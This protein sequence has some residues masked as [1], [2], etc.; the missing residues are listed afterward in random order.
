MELDEV[1]R[2]IV[3]AL[4]VDGR[5]PA[6]RI[7]EVLGVSARTVVRRLARLEGAGVLRVVRVPEVSAYPDGALV[8]RVR[9]LRGR[10]DVLA[11]ALAR[12][13]DVPFVDVTLG[14]EEVVALAVT[15][16]DARDRLLYEQLPATSA[17]TATTAQAVLHVFADAAHWRAGWLTADE[18]RA[19][20]PRPSSG[21]LAGSSALPP[22]AVGSG[23]G[24]ASEA[25]PFGP[26]GA[27]DRALLERLAVN[28]RV[29]AAEV[30]AAVGAPES[31]VRRHLHRL[32][33]AGRI[34]THATIDARLLGMTVD[35]TL[36]MTVPPARLHEI[37]TALAGHPHVH[38]VLATTGVTN[39]LATVFTP[40]LPA[41]YAFVTRVLGPL[42]V[43]GAETTVVGRAVKR[44]GVRQSAPG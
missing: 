13:E 19:L 40:D 28:A 16:P 25:E 20:E 14:G 6:G 44:A 1:D 41:L 31:T 4:Q 23:Q 24:E 3:C 29:G 22:G 39:L 33:A 30:A 17:V 21:P 18:I 11:D 26:L 42:G 32:G 34:R 5:A 27:L 2:R 9:V 35:A 7:G 37:G 8:L 10:T 36:W 43:P 15:G 12:R 38:G